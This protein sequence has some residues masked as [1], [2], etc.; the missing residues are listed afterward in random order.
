MH[1]YIYIPYTHRLLD[2][3]IVGPVVSHQ[4]MVSIGI[5]L[6][7]FS[8]YIIYI[9]NIIHHEIVGFIHRYPVSI[10]NFMFLKAT[11]NPIIIFTIPIY[12]KCLPKTY[13]KNSQKT[14]QHEIALPE[15]HGTS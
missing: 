7:Y 8:L 4:F 13:Q 3:P 6:F 12:S 14:Y 9:L 5:H 10:A 11:V 2:K 1:I 15:N